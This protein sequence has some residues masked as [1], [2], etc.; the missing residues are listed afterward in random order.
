MNRIARAWLLSTI[1]LACT[2]TAEAA[3]KKHI[4]GVFY[5]GCENTCQGFK[6][7]IA[8]SGFDADVTIVDLH[9][10]KSLLPKVVED[11]RA[12]KIDLVAV[13]GTT[14]TLG[15]TGTLDDVAD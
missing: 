15:I 10:D 7:G 12:K 5:E 9:Q 13:Y 8:A 4:L 3:G 1:L 11:A 6:A 2:A 14:G